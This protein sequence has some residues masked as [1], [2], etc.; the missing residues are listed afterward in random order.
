MRIVPTKQRLV[1][2]SNGG[3]VGAAVS[4]HR[5]RRQVRDEV[6]QSNPDGVIDFGK[7]KQYGEALRR[8][9]MQKL[10]YSGWRLGPLSGVVPTRRG[11]LCSI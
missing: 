9:P 3:S 2:L 6:T 7:E 1:P 5:V 11:S 8:P 10:S 4:S